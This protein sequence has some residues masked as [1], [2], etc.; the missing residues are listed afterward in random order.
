MWYLLDQW[1]WSW[2][3]ENIY[4]INTNHE[5]F[6]TEILWNQESKMCLPINTARGMKW[7]FIFISINTAWGFGVIRIVIVL[8]EETRPPLS[9]HLVPYNPQYLQLQGGLFWLLKAAGTHIIY[10]HT[11]RQSSHTHKIKINENNAWEYS[12]MWNCLHFLF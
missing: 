12:H 10:T 11:Y 5:G 8:A 9:T 2:I 3:S 7:W 6:L 1:I 4:T